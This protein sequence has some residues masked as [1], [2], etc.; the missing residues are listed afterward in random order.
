MGTSDKREI[1]QK[2]GTVI[3]WEN[4][5]DC[6]L[7]TSTFKPTVDL[8]ATLKLLITVCSYVC[9]PTHLPKMVQ[10]VPPETPERK[11]IS[12]EGWVARNLE[13]TW[14]KNLLLLHYPVTDPLTTWTIWSQLH[15]PSWLSVDWLLVFQA[16]QPRDP[17]CRLETLCFKGHSKH[18]CKRKPENP[19]AASISILPNYQTFTDK[20]EP[21]HQ[22]SEIMENFCTR[23]ILH[24]YSSLIFSALMLIRTGSSTMLSPSSLVENH[25]W[26][27][28]LK[29]L[30]KLFM[31]E[32]V[33]RTDNTGKPYGKANNPEKSRKQ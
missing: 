10:D 4:K 7:H 30:M 9:S 20:R 13:S 22:Q 18:D 16:P 3:K 28:L 26:S 29:E 31:F 17:D 21:N 5:M 12:T 11:S 1:N 6:P 14:N 25:F 33:Q 15:W 2:M 27:F 23:Q 19:P 8:T 24:S 32:A